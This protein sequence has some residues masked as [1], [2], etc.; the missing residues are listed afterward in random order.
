M[1]TAAVS[2]FDK[3]NQL[4]SMEHPFCS[5]PYSGPYLIIDKSQITQ[6]V[7]KFKHALPKVTPHY[8]V[9]ANPLPE[10]LLHLNDMDVNF[11]IA[12]EGELNLLKSLGVKPHRI[13]FSNPIKSASSI[14]AAYEFGIEWFAFD[15][16]EELLKLK[17]LAP[18][19]HYE[20]RISTNG[21]GS[22]WPLTKKFGVDI[23]DA[24]NLVE[25]AAQ[26]KINIAGLT[27]HVGSQCTDSNSW[28]AAIEDCK[29]LIS[30]MQNN[31]MNLCML[32][33]G[34]G[35]PSQLNESQLDFDYLMKP[36]NK[37]LQQ[38]KK[39]IVKDNTQ[40]LKVCAE[41]GRFLVSSSGTLFCQVIST[42][43]KK[44]LP[45]AFL[46]C[47]YYNGLMELSEDFGYTFKST[48]KG[49]MIPWT[50]AGPTCDSV[51]CFKPKYNLP[52]NLQAED[53]ISINNMGAY[54]S[55]CA[56]SFNGFSGPKVYLIE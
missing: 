14:K 18:N 4:A 54:V 3:Q 40:P 5:M 31:N 49:E 47:G 13:I 15:N 23:Q 2:F 24:I 41:P 11:E 1:N 48:K 28:I 7:L 27:F 42:T 53:I 50:I 55:T 16:L 33:I 19:A 51:D 30:V 37:A 43:I 22:V 39:D 20:L 10:V 9:K 35:F 12:S 26:H 21:K 17:K 45:W 36:V 29:N 6:Q 32:N 56:T 44:G 46:D 25:L 34:G 38:L 8:A 52:H